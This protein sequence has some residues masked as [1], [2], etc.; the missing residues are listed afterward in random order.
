M[1]RKAFITE[2]P[3]IKEIVNN[4]A[5]RGKL[6][7]LSL[8][9]IYDSLRDFFIYIDNATICGVCALHISWENI[10]EIR[11]LAV[12]E[13]YQGRQIGTQ[14]IK[15]SLDEAIELNIRQ[16]FCL[17]YRK[18][19]FLN[20]GF[21]IIDKTELPHKIWRDCYKCPKFPDCDEIAMIKYIDK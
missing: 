9:N 7:S 10:A 8:Q 12:K 4:F 5:S 2:A 3:T 16:V 1:I 6:L 21:Q 19:F 13:E 20:Q 15:A 14:L 11:S 18:N 17:T